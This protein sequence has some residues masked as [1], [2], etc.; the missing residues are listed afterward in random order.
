M[1]AHNPLEMMPL[2]ALDILAS[3]LKTHRIL[4]IELSKLSSSPAVESRIIF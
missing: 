1:S 2:L 4:E 3:E